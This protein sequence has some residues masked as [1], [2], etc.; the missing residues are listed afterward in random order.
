MVSMVIVLFLVAV[1]VSLFIGR[2]AETLVDR[3][4]QRA[5]RQKSHRPVVRPV[6]DMAK[7]GSI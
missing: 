2:L 5:E 4:R 6:A 7:N 3:Y 1:L